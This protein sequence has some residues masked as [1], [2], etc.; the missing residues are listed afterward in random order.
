MRDRSSSFELAG[1][2]DDIAYLPGFVLRAWAC[3]A[4]KTRGPEVAHNVQSCSFAQT[5]IG[6]GRTAR[7]ASTGRRSTASGLTGWALCH[8]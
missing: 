6:V 7:S 5:S 1:D 2:R 3:L 8:R 4:G